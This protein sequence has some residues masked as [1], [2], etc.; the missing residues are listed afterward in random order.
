MSG[1]RGHIAKQLT[2]FLMVVGLVVV[3]VVIGGYIVAHQRIEFPAWVPFIGDKG[4]IFNA[5][6]QTAQA[7]MPGQGQALTVAGVTVGTV[8]D[9]HLEN[10]RA[11]ISMRLDEGSDVTIHQDAQLLLRPKTGLKDMIVAMNPGT[12]S[13]PKLRAGQ[14]L[15]VAQTEPDVNLDEFLS[16]LDTDSRTYLQFLL[17]GAGTALKGQGPTLAA[18]LK[19]FDPTSRDLGLITKQLAVRQ[20]N[21]RH[22]VHNFKLLIQALGASDAQLSRFV[23]ASNDVLGTFA[24]ED[25]SLKA[26]L[27]GLPAALSHTEKGMAK[28]VDFTDVVAPALKALEP[29]SKNLGPGLKAM[30]PTLQH[31]QPIITDELRPFARAAKPTLDA[32][33]P[34]LQKLVPLTGSLVQTFDVFNYFLNEFG[35]NPGKD[36]AGFLFFASWASH[37]LNSVMGSGDAGGPQGR[38]LAMLQCDSRDV[39]N[40]VAE[41]NATARLLL[42]LLR[43]PSRT[44]MGCPPPVLVSRLSKTPRTK[45]VVTR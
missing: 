14:T 27:A 36:Q 40:G 32:I 43:P 3:A 12:A 6:F 22:A 29:T 45:A 26:T 16:A 8:Q 31:S 28:V 13:S 19:R 5:E 20:N 4:M 37:N 23:S 41:V 25:D 35:Y 9:V 44:E 17:N 21:I 7:V 10:G 11:I 30:I 18:V 34:A 42:G 38:G 24:T 2:D 39:L 33:T 1:L 15:S